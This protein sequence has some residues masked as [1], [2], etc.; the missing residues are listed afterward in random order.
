MFLT[1]KHGLRHL[2]RAGRGAVVCTASPTGL[3]GRAPGFDAYSSSKAGVYGLIRRSRP[4]TRA[5]ASACYGVA[6]GFTDTPMTRSFMEDDAQRLAL[7]QTIPLGRAAQP[8]D[9]IA[10]VV[11]FLLSDSTP[12]T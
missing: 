4:T 2:L 3:F 9:E 1:C 7:E 11:S 6:P 5:R 8:P 10:L 12:R